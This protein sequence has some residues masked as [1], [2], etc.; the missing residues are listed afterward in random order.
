[1]VNCAI[2]GVDW[3]AL[4]YWQ[5]ASLMAEWNLRHSDGKSEPTASPGGH[6]R[7]RKAMAAQT[8]H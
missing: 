4:R 2:M 7:M 8:R 5:Y 6:D 1:M 3:T